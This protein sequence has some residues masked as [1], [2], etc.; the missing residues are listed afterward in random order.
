M[1]LRKSHIPA[2]EIHLLREGI[3]ESTHHVHAVVCD[4]RG[5]VLMGAG[6]TDLITFP[7]SALKPFQ[8]L[9]VTTTGAIERFG[10]SDRDLAIICASHQG[11]PAQAR[12]VFNILWRADIEPSALQCPTPAGANS[13]LQYNCSGKHAGMLAA[14]KQMSVPLATYL[15][16]SHPVQQLILD[17]IADLLKMPAAEFIGARDDCGAPIYQ[18][19][20]RQMAQLYAIMAA[21]SSLDLERIV[22]A[23][24]LHPEMVSG[25]GN[26]DTEI[27][28]LTQ[29]EVVSKSGAEG[30]QCICR[31][32]EGVGIALKVVDGSQ[33]AKYAAAIH[34]LKQMGWL[35]GGAIESLEER[36]INIG[37]YKRLDAV[38]QMVG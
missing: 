38:G 29:G 20:L 22:R 32:R 2:L 18:M 17:K 21:G 4:D 11:S 5:R 35:S 10:L 23:M 26:F 12:Q 34:A 25:P 31:V 30:I 7:R 24:T 28:R 14:A 13:P 37:A 36:F 27:M 9:C 16:R 3:Q 1:T 33:R 6:D 15:H 8:A 19:E